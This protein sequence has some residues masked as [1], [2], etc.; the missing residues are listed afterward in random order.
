MQRD[1]HESN[2]QRYKNYCKCLLILSEITFQ[3]ILNGRSYLVS[4]VFTFTVRT[5]V[6]EVHTNTLSI[7]ITFKTTL[8]QIW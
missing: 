7:A 1:L 4:M 3:S 8:N 5:V 2:L 6:E